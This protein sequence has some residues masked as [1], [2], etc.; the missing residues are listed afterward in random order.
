[1]E[2][3][4]K[5]QV[6][7]ICSNCCFAQ[8][9]Y[10]KDPKKQSGCDFNR[11]EKF[12]DKELIHNSYYKI[13]GRICNFCRNDEWFEE[14][15]GKDHEELV[16]FENT[17]KFDYV[18]DGTSS[19]LTYWDFENYI[20]DISYFY[21][22]T[23]TIAISANCPSELSN[24]LFERIKGRDN[25]NI[26]IVTNDEVDIVQ[27]CH[28][29]FKATYHYFARLKKDL[30]PPFYF[31][32]EFNKAVNEDCRQI[33]LLEDPSFYVLSNA[34]FNSVFGNS[35]TQ[36]SRDKVKVLA[37]NQKKENLIIKYEDLLK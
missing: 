16:K 25:C 32:E 1:M 2:S 33:V 5:Q 11:L 4:E 23:L 29:K 35:K 24:K 7:S 12:P 37:A 15:K 10:S 13:K 14:N 20:D 18:I 6:F 17:I 31:C 21:I 26:M 28:K 36:T 30:I 22:K 3:K 9:D 27:E 8:W 19:L 34:C